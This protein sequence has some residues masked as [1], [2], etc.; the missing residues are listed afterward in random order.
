MEVRSG[1]GCFLLNCLPEEK[2][3]FELCCETIKIVKMK[4]KFVP[5]KYRTNELLKL[6]K[7]FNGVMK[8][9]PPELKTFEICFDAV[10]RNCYDL[11]YVPKKFKTKELCINAVKYSRWA[12]KYVPKKLL[13]KEFF[14][15]I[16]M[17]YEEGN[18]LYKI[19][20][21]KNCKEEYKAAQTSHNRTVTA[22]PPDGGSGYAKP[23]SG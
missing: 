2:I 23:Q 11:Q 16:N 1:D 5:Y 10:K 12:L 6:I 17:D 19:L 15:L 7:H 20:R 8:F 3:T 18:K 9:I 21:K 13:T 22:S 14:E 4:L